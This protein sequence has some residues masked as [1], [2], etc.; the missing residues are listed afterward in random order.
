MKTLNVI[1]WS[2]KIATLA[3]SG[4]KLIM[5][6]TDSSY[7]KFSPLL[8]QNSNFIE[9]IVSQDSNIYSIGIIND[10]IPGSYG[11]DYL[12]KYFMDEFGRTPSIIERLAFVGKH[13]LGALEFTPSSES[14]NID[15]E[16]YLDLEELKTQS[17]NIYEGEHSFELAKL[18]AMSN[19]AAG[20]AKAK[21]VIDFNPKNNKI[22]ISQKHN[23]PPIDFKK[24]IIKFNPNVEFGVEEYN[25][26]IKAEY[27]YYLLAKEV[28]LNMSDSW[29]V[30]DSS[31][32]YFIT[33]R[34]D[35][36]NDGNRLHMHS[37]AGM[38]GHDSSSFTM[39]Y[40]SLFRAG[41]MLGVSQYDKE[42]M[43]KTMVFN[44]VFSNRDDHSKNFSF[45][46]S[47]DG[48]WS[49]APAYDLTYS[50]HNYGASWHQL[51]IDKKPAH[52]ARSLSII[53][54][55]KLC[56]IKEPLSIISD[57]IKIKHNSL[58]KLSQQYNLPDSFAQ[59]VLDNTAEIDKRFLK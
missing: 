15:K 50:T 5:E 30:E 51:T 27:V 33:K 57:M 55:A 18:I 19:S 54:I 22:Y 1:A 35:I 12:N 59:S 43:F 21:A 11:K 3:Q 32:E 41:N 36:D 53:K 17:R 40:E 26:E 39:G 37:L 6:L 9:T 34:F 28:G 49:Y 29:L 31:S 52:N 47:K 10:C 45:L 25:N 7:S 58:A 42:Q 44:L 24:C 23:A 16:L 2:N 56:N 20:G 14:S 13:A 38:F 46:M 4:N 8:F 48:Q